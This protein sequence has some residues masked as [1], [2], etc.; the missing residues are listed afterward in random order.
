MTKYIIIISCI[1]KDF[2]YCLTTYYKDV[3]IWYVF[4]C[5]CDIVVVSSLFCC[6]FSVLSL[7]VVDML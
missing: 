4:V 1:G 7:G 6:C 2:Q 3:D 5:G